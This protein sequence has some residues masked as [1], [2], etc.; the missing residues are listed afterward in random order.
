MGKEINYH[1]KKRIKCL[2]NQCFNSATIIVESN[3]HILMMTLNKKSKKNL[4]EL[5]KQFFMNKSF[6]TANFLFV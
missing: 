4:R 5:M 6:S 3:I 2:R 1:N